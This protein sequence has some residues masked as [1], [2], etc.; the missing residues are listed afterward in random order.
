M[1]GSGKCEMADTQ[2]GGRS[3]QAFLQDVQEAAKGMGEGSVVFV[4]E[5]SKYE[6][7][8]R[9]AA[10]LLTKKTVVPLCDDYGEERN[11]AIAAQLSTEKPPKGVAAILFT[12][13]TSGMPK[14]V[15]LTQR[16]LAWNIRAIRRYMGERKRKIFI[17]R[18]LIHSAVFTGELLYALANGWDI[19]FWDGAFLPAQIVAQMK[20][21][22][23]EIAGMTPSLLKAF[24]RMRQAPPLK[25]I[26]L[27]GERL[28]REDAFYFA[29]KLPHCRFYSVYG[30]TECGPRVS[31]LP[32]EEFTQYAGSVG[33]PLHGVKLKCVGEELFVKTPGRMKGYFARSELTKQ[34]MLH[35]WIA[36]GDTA[37]IVQ[38][39]LYILGRKDDMIIRSGMNIY[40]SEVERLLCQCE[41]VEECIAYG[42]PDPV[43]GE[44]VAVDYSGTCSREELMTYAVMHLPA[45]LVPSEY[46]RLSELE[47]T[48]SGKLRR[49]KRE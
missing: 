7:A 15:M 2:I 32:P 9:I 18:P 43:C 3:G 39:R 19:V 8:V 1:R 5:R 30:L 17:F 33:L 4:R 12:S 14:G 37:R 36:T 29:E 38:R 23:A 16:A 41:G 25:E 47:R 21:T 13:G 26:I 28:T 22:G 46:H 24:L 11:H 45:Y 42:K 44:R 10:A 6:Q 31:A 40:P 49:R 35:G 20:E 27:S 48:E 34:K